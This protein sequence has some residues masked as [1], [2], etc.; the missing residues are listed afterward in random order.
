VKQAQGNA[1]QRADR[2]GE[3]APYVPFCLLPDRR[4]A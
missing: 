2:P 1:S 4:I 3:P